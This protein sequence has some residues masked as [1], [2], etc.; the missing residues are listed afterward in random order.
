MAVWRVGYTVDCSI[1]CIPVSIPILI[2]EMLLIGGK[3]K[4]TGHNIYAEPGGR[5][6][7]GGRNGAGAV[8]RQGHGIALSVICKTG[9]SVI[10]IEIY[11]YGQQVPFFYSDNILQAALVFFAWVDIS[12]DGGQYKAAE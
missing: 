12:G 1:F 8:C 10:F 3:V 2:I 11:V 9:G 4:V 7:A 5:R 6:F